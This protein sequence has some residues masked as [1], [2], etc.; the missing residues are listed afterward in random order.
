[1]IRACAGAEAKGCIEST[2]VQILLVETSGEDPCARTR[3]I[4]PKLDCNEEA[5]IRQF[6]QA[7]EDKTVFRKAL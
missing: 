1:M 4:Y 3:K 5:R 2:D 6:S 7:G